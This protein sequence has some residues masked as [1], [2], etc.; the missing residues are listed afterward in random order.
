MPAPCFL[1]SSLSIVIPDARAEEDDSWEKIL[2]G[3]VHERPRVSAKSEA[4]KDSPRPSP[5]PVA[6]RDGGPPGCVHINLHRLADPQQEGAG[7][8]DPPLHVGDREVK[9]QDPVIRGSLNPR[10]Q[11]DFVIPAMD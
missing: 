11:S 6:A 1:E 5:L 10:R 3:R 2:L 8:L 4:G 7:V 9:I